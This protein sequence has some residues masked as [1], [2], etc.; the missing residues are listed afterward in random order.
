MNIVLFFY[1]KN[2]WFIYEG[3]KIYF[4]DVELIYTS[5]ISLYYN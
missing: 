4:M 1:K 2:V 3:I 5:L